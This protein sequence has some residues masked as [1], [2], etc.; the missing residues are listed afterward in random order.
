MSENDSEHRW[1]C[2][3]FDEALLSNALGDAYQI[4]AV[5]KK[6]SKLE[7]YDSFE[8]CFIKNGLA[9][10]RT[11]SHFHI[12]DADDLI[13]NPI[14]SDT[15]IRHQQPV[16]HWDFEPGA[17]QRVL[18]SHLKLRAAVKLA[19]VTVNDQEYCIRNRDGKT[20]LR[21]WQQS[22]DTEGQIAMLTLK[23]A[24]LLGYAKEADQIASLISKKP[25]F[26]CDHI[27]LASHVLS[28]VG[29][30]EAP[31]SPKGTIRIQSND[32]V[33]D[34]V[35]KIAKLMVVVA[36]QSEQGIIEDI[37]T[38][39]LHDY[40]VGIRKLRSVIALVKGAYSKEDTKRL[41]DTFGD[42]ARTTNRLRDLDVYLL[43]EAEYRAQLPNELQPG[44][45]RM[46]GDFRAERR[47]VQN[48]VRRDIQ[49]TEYMKSMA[50]QFK[51]LGRS[52][53]PKGARSD[54]PIGTVVVK[55]IR[56]HHKLVRTLGIAIT[57][58]TP[59]TE[60][61]ELRIECKKLR[62][63]LELFASLFP[64][65]E[66]RRILRRLRGL[67]NV[68]GDFN[69]CS[70]QRETMLEYLD[71]SQ[72][73]DKYSAAAVGGLISILHDKQLDARD[74]VTEKFKEF[75]DGKMRQRFNTLFE[76]MENLSK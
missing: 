48:K 57:D 47:R 56:K 31:L 7:V 42:Y 65:Q 49:S 34:S 35:T 71:K 6:S 19:T 28:L 75:S 45:D 61:H 18:R 32:T 38:E 44:L 63:L 23:A 3:R 25:E 68:L 24:P 16:S 59:D 43:N 5:S 36:R 72:D 41:K 14:H 64:A 58:A 53:R 15:R 4:E 73:L 54:M 26:S 62:Y 8:Q 67:Q 76:G 51:W 27:S 30:A 74:H 11:A 60:V 37:D 33:T 40:R 55:E 20:I 17:F 10:I 50:Q 21:L 66:M 2:A 12:A 39:F 1:Q 9:L 13:S 46:F 52:K 69:D 22:V 29:K 70:V